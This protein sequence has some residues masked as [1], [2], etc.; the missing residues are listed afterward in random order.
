MIR[1]SVSGDDEEVRIV[2]HDEG[3]GIPADKLDH[4]FEMFVQGDDDQRRAEYGGLG[5]GLTL[6]R[7]LVHLHGGILPVPGIQLQ[8]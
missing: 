5:L 1:V 7:E 4:I 3:A 6:V 8:D 2:V